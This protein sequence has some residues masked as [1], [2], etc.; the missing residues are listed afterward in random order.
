LVLIATLAT[1]G[2]SQE[3][4]DR[5]AVMAVVEATLDAISLIEIDQEWRI[6]SI[7][8][9]RR[10]PPDCRLHPDGPPGE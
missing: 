9:T 5:A 7:A 2:D 6:A 8:Y 10:Q 3:V 1:P 4:D